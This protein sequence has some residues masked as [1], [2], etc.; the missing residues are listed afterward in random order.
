MT[1]PG[2]TMQLKLVWNDTEDSLIFDVVNEQLTQWFVQ[3]SNT[4]GS[5]EYT[6]GT[7]IVDELSKPLD[8]EKLIQEEIDYITK[9]NVYLRRLKM[10]EFIFPT[11]WYSQSEL[12]RLHK[13]W[14]EHRLKWPKM[15]EVFYKIDPEL[16]G[17]YQE[18][19]CHIHFIEKSFRY[20]FR[21][22]KYWRTDNP[23]KKQSYQW[24]VSNLYLT[25]P[26]HG[27]FA[28]EKFE[29]LD[30]DNDMWRDDCNWDNIDP[31]LEMNLVRPYNTNPPTEFLEWCKANNLVPHGS[32]IPLANLHDWK[33][34]LTQARQVATKNVKI[35]NNSF[36]LHLL[37]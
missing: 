16:F 37:E 34:T 27:R 1:K 12:N 31:F 8:T 33:N 7:Q 15:S 17:A 20:K 24:A 6:V 21:D 23:F 9:V 30:T 32:S 4:L 10:P 26:G 36:S 3:T 35:P 14:A 13:D 5:N 19:N 2:I 28:F 29:N 22:E 11:S 18:M 25:Y